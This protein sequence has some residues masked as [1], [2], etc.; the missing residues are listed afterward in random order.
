MKKEKVF[1]YSL[2]TIDFG[3]RYFEERKSDIS[4]EDL[5]SWAK[6][7]FVVVDTKNVIIQSVATK[8]VNLL[9]DPNFVF[10]GLVSF[11]VLEGLKKKGINNGFFRSTEKVFNTSLIIVDKKDAY[12]VYDENNIYKIDDCVS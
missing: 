12:V 1:V 5:V 2:N 6:E 8:A 4:L 7:S 11:N 3:Y 9:V 10:I